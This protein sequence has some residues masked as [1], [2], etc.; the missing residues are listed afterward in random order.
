MRK[1]NLEISILT[2]NLDF[3]MSCMRTF[4]L[5]FDMPPCTALSSAAGWRRCI[6]CLNLQVFFRKRATNYRVFLQE[7]TLLL[8]QVVRVFIFNW[9]A[10]MHIYVCKIYTNMH[11]YICIY[12]YV[13]VCACVWMCVCV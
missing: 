6:G 3:D 5:V 13:C 1:F 4:N 12:T 2:F 8:S 10:R 9:R 7:N 11:A